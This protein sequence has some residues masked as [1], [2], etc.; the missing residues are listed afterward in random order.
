LIAL[1][2]SLLP[3][4]ELDLGLKKLSIVAGLLLLASR[5]A[6]AGLRPSA[7]AS[8]AAQLCTARREMESRR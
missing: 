5:F 3:L 1:V 2:F 8:A 7:M 6:F 4:P